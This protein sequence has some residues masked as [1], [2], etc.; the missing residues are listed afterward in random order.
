MTTTPKLK[1]PMIYIPIPV[2][3]MLLKSPYDMTP[4]GITIHNTA[5]TASARQEIAYMQ[6]N[7]LEVSYHVA[8]D[9]DEIVQ[10]VRFDK[11][12]WHASDGRYGKGNRTTIGVEICDSLDYTTDDY[13]KAERNAVLYCAW[14]LY[15]RGWTTERLHRH[16]DWAY[17]KKKCPHRMFEG[18]PTTWLDFLK[19]VNKE[20]LQLKI[21]LTNEVTTTRPMVPIKV[22]DIVRLK[23]TATTYSTGQNIP[24]W[25]K[26]RTHTVDAIG[27]GKI[28]LK[29]IF[30]WVPLDSIVGQGGTTVAY[31]PKPEPT[32]LQAGQRVSIKPTA[33]YYAS[34]V[35]KV[36]I[37]Q[38][39]KERFH[40][41]LQVSGDKVLLKEI[42]SWVYIKDLNTPSQEKPAPIAM[43]SKVKIKST[44]R[45]YQNTARPT[46]I[47]AW[48]KPKTY[49][50]LQ[51]SG[52]KVLLKEI[53]SW[54]L[55]TDVD[56]V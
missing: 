12:G 6:R 13:E 18:R 30:S 7:N 39:V 56:A 46:E 37:P 45:Y 19:M 49:T 55:L 51:V 33:L 16:Y 53:Y 28:R 44:A 5:N 43:G 17:N 54:V 25:V 34:T 9:K 22:G 11:N 3:K 42:F 36:A 27:D 35:S 50:V 14:E 52:N 31:K 26:D 4:E 8:I 10:G 2:E 48:V 21:E 23:T 40:T 41:V 15:R 47:P 20:L 38:F 1:V 24:Q 29:E 32:T